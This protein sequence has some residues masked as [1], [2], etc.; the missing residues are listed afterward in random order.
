ML[1]PL[2]ILASAGG[3][4][5]IVS[6]YE[7]ISTTV[8]GSN[9]AS[10]VFDVSSF[11]S[12]YKHLQIRAAVRSIRADTADQVGIRMNGD[13]GANYSWHYLEG[14]GS[15]VY[16]DDG[17]SQTD[18]FAGWMPANTAGANI[19]SSFVTDYLDVYSTTKNKTLR[20]SSGTTPFNVVSLNSGMRMN[21]EALTSI[22]VLSRL[23]SQFATGSRFSLYGIKG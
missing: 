19:F 6:D 23:S 14:N 20:H 21:T 18:I 10:V 16:S 7:L 15:S 13:T 12:T 1:I 22:T 8:L 3:V 11:S 5:P 4:P 17:V 2:G 9:Q